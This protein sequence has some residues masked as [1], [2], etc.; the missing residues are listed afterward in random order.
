MERRVRKV[1][2]YVCTNCYAPYP[3]KEAAQDHY[4]QEHHEPKPSRPP[5][6]PP[7]NK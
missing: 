5:G 7:K 2:V 4:D 3:T 6:R 1:T